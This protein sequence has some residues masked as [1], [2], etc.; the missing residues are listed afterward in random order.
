MSVEVECRH[1]RF[2]RCDAC[3]MDAMIHGHAQLAMAHVVGMALV[4]MGF[5]W[6]ALDYFVLGR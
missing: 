6:M 4:L 3:T 2:G 5:A 1:G